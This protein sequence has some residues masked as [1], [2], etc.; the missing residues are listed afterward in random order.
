MIA[1]DYASGSYLVIGYPSEIL[2]IIPP[3]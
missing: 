1:R 2:M 3:S